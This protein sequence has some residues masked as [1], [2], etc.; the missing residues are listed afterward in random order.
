MVRIDDT[1]SPLRSKISVL[2]SLFL[3]DVTHA[4][5]GER[6]EEDRPR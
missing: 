3:P 6:F 1:E 4:G 2:Q 5:L